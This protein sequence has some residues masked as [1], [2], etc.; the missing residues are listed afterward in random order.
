MSTERRLVALCE[1]AHLR[2]WIEAEIADVVA[3]RHYAPSVA[4]VLGAL[5]RGGAS[6][7]ELLVLDLDLMSAPFVYELHTGLEE[8][9][10]GGRIIGL[11]SV[12]GVHRR[13]LEIECAVPR[14]FGSESLRTI[15]AGAELQDADCV[16]TQPLIAWPSQ[17]GGS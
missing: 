12:R 10:W 5:G 1:S 3:S 15:V 8:R 6:K 4:G 9:W 16:D 13:Y 11:G 2:T 14:P 17:R 7:C